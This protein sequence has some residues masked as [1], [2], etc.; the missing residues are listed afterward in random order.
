MEIISQ[1][2]LK[3]KEIIYRKN[4]IDPNGSLHPSPGT[5]EMKITSEDENDS[6]LY[7]PSQF[8]SHKSLELTLK[9]K[10]SKFQWKAYTTSIDL[11]PN[12]V[13]SNMSKRAHLADKPVA[14]SKFKNKTFDKNTNNAESSFDSVENMYTITEDIDN[15]QANESSG[16]LCSL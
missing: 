2:L 4:T 15:E 7:P 6:I 5:N 1:K 9:K 11:I 10:T 12:S 14:V 8:Q 16:W 3:P 13:M